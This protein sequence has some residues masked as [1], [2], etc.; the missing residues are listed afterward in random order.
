M[1]YPA[2]SENGFWNYKEVCGLMGAKYPA[3]PLGMITVAAL[4]PPDWQVRLI[5]ANTRAF[6]YAD[7]LEAD[8][9]F[10]GGMLP[11]QRNILEIIRIAKQLSIPV[12]V[13]GPDPSSQPHIYEEADYLILGEAEVTLPLFLKDFLEG[14][15]QKIY[16]SFQK[17]DI[18]QSPVPRYDLLDF[19]N[20]LMI[21]V[22]FCRGCPFNCEFC[23]IIELYGRTP[24]GKTPEQIIQEL[25]TLYQL[26]YR[27]HIDFVDDN[28]I[29]NK[30]KSKQILRAVLNWS[31]KRNYPFFFSTEASINLADDDELLTLM[32]DL[33]FRYVFIGLESPSSEILKNTQK[34]HNLARKISEDLKKIYSYGIVVNAGF[35]VGFDEETEEIADLM[36]QTIEEGKI[37]MAMVGL[38]FALPNTQL[39]KRL[40]KENRLIEIGYR[41]SSKDHIDQATSGLNFIT[42]RPADQIRK[43]FLKI[44]LTVYEDK[45]YF[46]R[47]LELGM[48]LQI[49]PRHKRTFLGLLKAL[50]AFLKLSFKISISPK[51][52]F[53]Y[54]RNIFILLF[55]KPSS[56]ETIINLMA[57][58]L[59]FKKQTE[60][61]RKIFQ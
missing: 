25:E 22:Q 52:S 8:M 3:A 50:K 34:F 16:R 49:K 23:D 43:D 57:M 47:L 19:K 60:F 35:I 46:D 59:H 29:G 61:I 51:R 6:S 30:E 53:Y 10:T 20:Y 28:F 48:L 7:F 17:P 37:A 42:K 14:K 2:F 9:I 56:L 44:I 24:R 36:I 13:G 39:T 27:G 41:V 1:I 38:L 11:Q 15:A 58:H 12:V 21:G 18:T 5:D 45:K 55:K 32:R 4:L 33:D 54:W 26:G 31:Q 40:A